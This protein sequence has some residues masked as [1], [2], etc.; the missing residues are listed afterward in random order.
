MLFPVEFVGGHKTI[1]NMISFFKFRS[2]GE[3]DVHLPIIHLPLVT[4]PLSF[5]LY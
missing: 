3:G 4:N 5:A 1:P 2:L